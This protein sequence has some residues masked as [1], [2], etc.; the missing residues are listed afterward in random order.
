MGWFKNRRVGSAV[1]A[2][3]NI[4]VAQGFT[5]LALELMKGFVEA[6]GVDQKFT[7]PANLLPQFLAKVRI[8]NEAIILSSLTS[9]AEQDSR[10]KNLLIAFERL[11]FPDTPTGMD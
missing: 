3:P 4:Q 9:K 1:S 7:V 6:G 11:V 10:Y 8:Y 5:D 2:N